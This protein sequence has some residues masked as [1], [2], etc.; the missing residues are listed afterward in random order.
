MKEAKMQRGQLLFAHYLTGSVC[1]RDNCEH[2]AQ[3][4]TAFECATPVAA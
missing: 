1:A 2:R 3:L 4:L